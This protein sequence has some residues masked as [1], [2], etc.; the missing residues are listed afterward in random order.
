MKIMQKISL[1]ILKN[2]KMRTVFTIMGIILSTAL[3]TAVTSTVTSMESMFEKIAY[4]IYGRWHYSM[5]GDINSFRDNIK[6]EKEVIIQH[7]GY[8]K[9]KETENIYK[10]YLYIRSI[11]K[12]YDQLVNLKIINGRMPVKEGEIVLPLH[13]IDA[14]RDKDLSIGSKIELN[15]GERVEKGDTSGNYLGQ[16]YSIRKELDKNGNLIAINEDLIPHEQPPK[17]YT[18]VGHIKRNRQEEIFSPGYDCF[19]HQ[20]PLD[21]STITGINDYHYIKLASPKTFIDDLNLWAEKKGLSKEDLDNSAHHKIMA[22]TGIENISKNSLLLSVHQGSQRDG[23]ENTLYIIAGFVSI[24]IFLAS[25]SLIYNAFSISIAERTRDFG[26]LV[27]IGSS[28]RQIRKAVT[29]EAMV[30]SIIAIPLGI[31]VGIIGIGITFK[32]LS[33]SFVQILGSSVPNAEQIEVGIK[34]SYLGIVLAVIISAITVFVSSIIPARRATKINAIDA[35]RQTKDIKVDQKQIRVSILTRKIFGFPAVIATKHFKRAKKAYRTTIFSLTTSILLFLTMTSA[36][37][38]VNKSLSVTTKHYNID[39]SLDISGFTESEKADIYNRILSNEDVERFSQVT[40][41]FVHDNEGNYISI[42]FVD[43]ASYKKLLDSNNLSEDIKGSIAFTTSLNYDKATDKYTAKDV[44]ENKDN[45]IINNHKLDIIKI[46]ENPL[47][48]GGFDSPSIYYPNSSIEEIKA[49]LKLDPEYKPSENI[50]IDT[51]ADNAVKV[52]EELVKW[53]LFISSNP[54]RVVSSTTGTQTFESLMNIIS[55]F[56]YGFIILIALIAA[57]NVFNTITTNI[58]LRKREFAV[59][60]S[61][62]MDNAGLRRMIA[63][64]SW[65]YGIKSTIYGTISG[66]ALTSLL[67]MIVKDSMKLTRAEALE[68][69]VPIKA[70]VVIVLGVFLLVF[71]SSFYSIRKARKESI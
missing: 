24:I 17:I 45:L 21:P 51:T 4:N 49:K 52:G 14:H 69:I 9:I 33:G 68:I 62:G 67:Y 48:V 50:F 36:I 20:A 58:N 5:S 60:S 53:L 29:F 27:S 13:Y 65:L 34:L 59:L 19:I 44:L 43:E 12:D 25:I 15:L 26:L 70:L 37:F 16:Y 54:D 23:F 28:K 6:V 41:F 46:R 64:E 11:P 40:D 42:R 8:H 32:A 1:K 31:M 63:F 18:I 56:S 22:N 7:I 39:I 61:V 30:I 55:V 38:L 47:A 3:F 66:V 57:T 2:N 10:P 35:I 71:V